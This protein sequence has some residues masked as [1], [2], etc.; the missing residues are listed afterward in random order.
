M[1]FRIY[2]KFIKFSNCA[3]ATPIQNIEKSGYDL[4]NKNLLI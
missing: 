2:T 1:T 3:L 4:R